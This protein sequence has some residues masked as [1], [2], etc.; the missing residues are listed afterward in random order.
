MAKPQIVPPKTSALAP[1]VQPAPR[2]GELR[3][4]RRAAKRV[5]SELPEAPPTPCRDYQTLDALPRPSHDPGHMRRDLPTGTVT[6]LFTDV[7]GSTKLLHE[8][9]AQAYARE[10]ADHR[11]VVREA[12]NARGG[13]EVDTQGDAFFVAFP[14]AQGALEAAR[15]ITEVLASGPMTLRIGLH[16]G[17][18]FLTDE[19]YVGEEV[20]FAARVAASAHGGQVV[21][22]QATRALLDD[23]YPLVELGEHRL[24]DIPEPVAIFQLGEHEFPPLKTISN[25]NLPRPASSFVGRERELQDVLAAI[26]AGA[27]LLTLTGPGG[28]GKTRLALEAAATL[29]PEYKAGVFWVGLASLFDAALVSETISQALGAKDSLAEH[30]GEREMLLLLDNLEQVIEAAPELSSLLQRCRNLT[31]LVTSRELLRVQGEIEYAVPPLADAEATSLF[32]ERAQ[33]QQSE[34]ISELCRRLDNLPLAVEL[35]AARAKALSPAQILD[36]LSHRLDLLKGGRDADPRQQTLRATIEWSYDLLRPEEQQLFARLSVFAGGS[37]LDAAEE[38]VGAD[39]DTLQSLVEKNLL[40]FSDERYWMLETIR[41]YAAGRLTGA[42]D[43]DELRRKHARVYA[44]L[45]ADMFP[46]LRSHAAEAFKTLGDERANTR[47]ALDFSLERGEV[48]VA[49]DLLFGLWFY[50][51]MVGSGDEAAEWVRRY[52]ASARHRLSPVERLPGDLAAAEI[53]RFTGEPEAAAMLKREQL[54]VTQAH[55]NEV[56]HGWRLEKWAAG[57]LSDLSYIEADA[58]RV[59]EARAYAEEALAL[60][61]SLGEPRGVGHALQALASVAYA[62]GDFAQSR[63]YIL[64]SLTAYESAGDSQEAAHSAIAIAECDLL[65]GR[66]EEAGSQLRSGV[67]GL[68]AGELLEVAYALRVAG[69]LAADRGDHETCAVLFGAA[70]HG[71][72]ETGFRVFAQAQE[73]VYRDYLSRARSNLGEPTFHA[74]H[75]RGIEAWGPDALALARDSLDRPSEAPSAA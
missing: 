45:V 7:E 64:E 70:D 46:S 54:E 42:T 27:G 39:V 18:P 61:R 25:T 9:G 69:M 19:G 65:L 67:Q 26:A 20:H 29:V 55:P 40:R 63:D 14:T 1:T 5:D 66:L 38:V 8:L 3:V 21:L 33:T 73:D 30:I 23:R 4:V 17:I 10:L 51:L 28:S 37:T 11:S 34:E 49:S 22:S 48:V 6:F 43:A 36:R 16:T 71:Y 35:A 32:C 68:D 60:R 44:R 58:E 12:C 59:Q 72:Q 62:E 50:W 56:V 47:G 52:L 74:A 41:E 13:V 53:L 2:V 24:K 57:L 31:L 75:E 15:S